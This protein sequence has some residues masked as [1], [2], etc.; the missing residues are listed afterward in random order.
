MASEPTAAAAEPISTTVCIV[1]GGFSTMPLIRELERS[2]TEYIVVDPGLPSIWDSMEKHQF[3][4]DLVSNKT[5]SYYSFG[6]G[7]EYEGSYF[8]MG[9][10]FLEFQRHW[11]SQL[12]HKSKFIADRVETI[13]HS[14]TGVTAFTAGG[15]EIRAEYCVAG[16]AFKRAIR[17]SLLS[18]DYMAIQN[19]TILFDGFGDSS[20]LMIS[21]MLGRGN[22]F[23]ILSDGFTMLQKNFVINDEVWEYSHNM[24]EPFDHILPIH[25]RY[26]IQSGGRRSHP[27]YAKQVFTDRTT[28]PWHPTGKGGGANWRTNGQIVVKPWSIQAYKHTYPD[29]TEEIKRGRLLDDIFFLMST[30]EIQFMRRARCAHDKENKTVTNGKRSIKYDT[31][32]T[33]DY[34]SAALPKI[35]I[36][37]GKKK[38]AYQYSFKDCYM[39]VVPRLCDRVLL[40]GYTRPH[41]D[42]LCNIIEMQCLLA[43]HIITE[44]SFLEQ[45]RPKID[46][47]IDKYNLIQYGTVDRKASAHADHLV[48][49]SEYVRTLA[50]IIGIPRFS[51]SLVTLPKELLTQW[52][53]PDHTIKWRRFGKYAVENAESYCGSMMQHH[54]NYVWT[55]LFLFRQCL[56]YKLLLVATVGSAAVNMLGWIAAIFPLLLLLQNYL[57]VINILGKYRLGMDHGIQATMG[58]LLL[59][60]LA[61]IL[62]GTVLALWSPGP[63]PL[64]WCGLVLYFVNRPERVAGPMLQDAYD[65]STKDYYAKYCQLIREHQ[66]STKFD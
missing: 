19:Q 27:L 53:L 55:T 63:W 23:Y 43:H 17:S 58:G 37:R 6:L 11:R 48:M 2:H 44:P 13:E 15:V 1:G 25:E 61:P 62:I 9:S 20:K 16:T 8:P 40:L 66:V 18:T 10:E 28:D 41:F 47:E 35:L 24:A 57:F 26:L 51:G 7:S 21:R 5:S 39:G 33:T 14:S 38:T 50:L 60:E 32:F 42:G 22:K 56:L 59:H 12:H 64:V 31:V 30:G 49:F 4:F 29:P 65:D 54:G 45:L 36:C 52:L 3:D 46:D 34:E